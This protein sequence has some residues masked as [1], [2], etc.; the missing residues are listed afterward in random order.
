[1]VTDI[2]KSASETAQEVESLDG[3]RLISTQALF[4]F[5]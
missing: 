3:G 1:M 5:S 4:N 2:A